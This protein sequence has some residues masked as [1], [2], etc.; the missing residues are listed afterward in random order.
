MLRER[1]VIARSLGVDRALVT[2][3]EGNAGSIGAIE[4]CGGVLESRYA[5]PGRAPIRRYWID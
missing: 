3:D 5:P 4:R 2:C 1:L